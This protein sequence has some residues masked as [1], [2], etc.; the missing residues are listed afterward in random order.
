M[1]SR[2][3]SETITAITI[4]TPTDDL[5]VAAPSPKAPSPK[6]PPSPATSI[7]EYSIGNKRYIVKSVYIGT[8][9]AGTALLKL[10]ERKAMYEMGLDMTFQPVNQVSP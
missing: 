8:Q 3:Q 6:I 10:A 4:C 1:S 9:D 7:N 5:A 2:I